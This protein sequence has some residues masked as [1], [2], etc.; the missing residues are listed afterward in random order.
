M[1]I[2]RAA[3]YHLLIDHSRLIAAIWSDCS[4][5]FY[6]SVFTSCFE[7]RVALYTLRM[8]LTGMHCACKLLL[9]LHLS[10]MMTWCHFFV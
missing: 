7:K 1:F 4:K 10:S 2:D 9:I 8:N 3:M 6:L 5:K